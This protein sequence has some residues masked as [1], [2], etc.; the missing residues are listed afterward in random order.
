MKE[1]IA[2]VGIAA[3]TLPAFALA[4]EPYAQCLANANGNPTATAACHT[5]Y[6]T[7]SSGTTQ[8]ETYVPGQ[9]T[10]SSTMLE[11]RK[12]PAF[13][14]CYQQASALTSGYEA[15][16]AECMKKYPI[17][18]PASSPSSLDPQCLSTVALGD[19]AAIASCLKT[20]TSSTTVSVSPVTSSTAQTSTDTQAQVQ[21]LLTM[22]GQ[23]QQ[24]I[25]LLLASGGTAKVKPLCSASRSMSE[26]MSGGDITQL[27]TLLIARGFLA[28]GNSTGFFGPLTEAAV[29]QLQVALGIVSS[30]TPE[31]T[32][33]GIAGPRTRAA[34]GICI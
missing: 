32:G 15:A 1:I 20:N 18:Q 10:T 19:Q 33:W 26:G 24:S 8:K 6:S 28:A 12:N 22:I 30:G 11:Y 25:D 14:T 2:S 13:E 27:Q 4:L 21:R 29:Q 34:L 17:S 3:L 16:L 23:L 31:S 9:Q 7:P 5:Q